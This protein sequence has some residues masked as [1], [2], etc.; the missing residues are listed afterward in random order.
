MEPILST[1]EVGRT[2]N[3]QP[4]RITYAINTGQ[5]KEASFRFL[6]KRCFTQSD[7]EHIAKHFGGRTEMNCEETIE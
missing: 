2:L 5:I 6:G 3:I 4:Y 1:G 7:V